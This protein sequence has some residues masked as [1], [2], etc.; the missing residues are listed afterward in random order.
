MVHSSQR[1]TLGMPRAVRA[2]AS[3]LVADMLESFH[4][5][6]KLNLPSSFVSLRFAVVNFL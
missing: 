3:Q 6:Q 5:L 1:T 2:A 4:H